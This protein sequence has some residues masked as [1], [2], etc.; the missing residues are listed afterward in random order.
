MST[1]ETVSTVRQAVTGVV[2]DS[3]RSGVLA[4]MRRRGDL[5]GRLLDPA[6][7]TDPYPTYD[8]LREQGRVVRADLGVITTSHEM[9]SAVLRHPSVVSAN[10]TRDSFTAGTPAFIRW[11]FSS[12]D[13][14]G[15]ID[16]IGADSM[17][18]MDGPDHTRLRRLVSSVFTPAAVERLRGRLEAITDELLD[19]AMARREFDVMSALAGPLPVRAICAVLGVPERDIPRFRSWGGAIAADLDSLSPAHRQ[20]QATNALRELERYFDDLVERRRGEPGD[21]ILSRLV[22]AEADGSRLSH[23]ELVTMATLLLFAGFETT[24]NLIGNGT[25]ALLDHP[26]QYALLREDPG[27]I[28]G[29]VEEMLRFDAPVQTVARVTTRDVEICGERLPAGVMVSTMIG[30]ANRDPR[31]FEH[32]ERFD[33][34]RPNARAHLSFA[35][36]PHHCLGASL[37]RLEAQIAFARLVERLPRLEAAGPRRRRRTFILRGYRSVPVVSRPA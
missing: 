24:V 8:W 3:V 28:P 1:M 23:R 31:V 26:E 14:T 33:V 18:G 7:F 5:T 29:A 10:A 20:R 16:P 35:L 21:D 4:G 22:A 13:R 30:G 34:V 15:L 6:M 36:G 27:L 12:P 11:L 32:P 19:E 25:A 2:R 37:A 17:I 9:C